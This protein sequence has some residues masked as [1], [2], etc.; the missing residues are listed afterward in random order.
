MRFWLL[1]PVA[2]RSLRN[3]KIAAA[4]LAMAAFYAFAI[5]LVPFTAVAPDS[6]RFMHFAQINADRA[7]AEG[8]TA[9]TAVTAAL[10][11]I[12]G[13][14]SFDYNR[15]RLVQG[16]A[17]GVDAMTRWMLPFATFNLL[18]ILVLSVNAAMVSTLATREVADR[19]DRL[20]L[21]L[22]SW[23]VLLTSALIV[24][25][26]MLLILYGK[27]IWITFVLA[28]FVA[29]KAGWK[30][31]WLIPAA[32]ADEIGLVAVALIAF[33]QVGRILLE[34][35][36]A[37]SLPKSILWAAA[38][39]VN[40]VLVFF[41]ISALVFN[42]G[43]GT[44]SGFA[45]RG[46]K[47][48]LGASQT[49]WEMVQG[50]FWR[51]EVLLLG[52]STNVTVITSLI[53]LAAMVVISLAIHRRFSYA[54]RS[55]QSASGKI[56]AV[57]HATLTNPS[58][59]FYAFWTA[60]LVIVAWLILPGRGGDLTHYSYPAAILLAVLLLT[61][62]VDLAAPRKAAFVL[63]GILGL[64]LVL[65]PRIVD[66]TSRIVQSYLLNDGTVSVADIQKLNKGIEEIRSTGKSGTFDSIN[67][68]QEIDFSGTWYYSRVRWFGIATEPH[69]PVQGTVR[70]LTWPTHVAFKCVR[71]TFLYTRAE[72]VD[73]A[74]PTT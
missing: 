12:K 3:I 39:A 27:Y 58:L 70:V 17:Y 37:T 51:S 10:R 44:F 5:A 8:G 34:R 48:A 41:G 11:T 63:G 66:S 7:V 13:M 42:A 68:G 4:V 61:A 64:H 57:I 54:V 22:L 69:W 9:K 59:S 65:M 2:E 52:L 62:L 35:R 67:N 40:V 73:K 72:F 36:E 28:H 53:G 25:P 19:E 1:S 15:G 60:M 56:T 23:M 32:Y 47:G 21:A 18:M 49:P 46:L 16:V 20:N 29:R 38:A 6:I 74:C 50:V 71:R 14:N 45:S 33:F 30:V 31:F 26:V 55:G 43:A 24:S